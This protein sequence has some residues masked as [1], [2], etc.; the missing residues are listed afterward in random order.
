VDHDERLTEARG[1]LAIGRWEGAQRVLADLIADQDSP[2]AHDGMGTA[3]WW[4]CRVRESLD[5][6][7]RAY[8]G[9]LAQQRH[10]DAAMVALDIG[11]CHV[12]NLDNRVA[13]QGWIA[14]ARRSAEVAG[15]GLLDGWLWLMEAY[16][17]DDQPRQRALLTQT[18][19]LARSVGDP[20]LE[21][22]ALADL[23]LVLVTQGE[24]VDGLTL[25]DE[26]MAGTLGGECQRLDTV[27]W[28][29]CSMLAACSLVGDHRRASQ[30]TAAADR[31]AEKY[32]C[33][34][35]Q[36]RCRSHYGRVLVDIGDWQQAEVELNQA[37]AMSLDCGRE[38]RIEALA[39][40]AE[41]RL[42]AGAVEEAAAM[43][44]EVGDLP[45]AAVISAEV[46]IAQGHPD[47]A[48]A[49]LQNRLTELDG[50][51]AQFPVVAAALV[52]ACIA[53]G[54]VAAA[55]AAAQTLQ[56][57]AP[58]QHPQTTALGHR[59][60][61]L[62]AASVGDAA[63]AEQRLRT[64]VTDFERLDLPFQA[65]RTRFELARAIADANRSLAIV[66]ASR[67]LAGLRRLGAVREASATAQFLRRLGVAARPGPRQA[68]MLSRR[69]REVLDRLRRGLT[70]P[71][72]AAQLFISPRTV[73]H[74]VS[75]ILTKLDLKTR[76]EAAAYAASQLRQ[77]HTGAGRP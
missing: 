18:L 77:D 17:C 53:S 43:L 6:R 33:P 70:N 47:R 73:G 69:E 16:T 59:A 7:E 23:G 64:A 31:F 28:A 22:A 36:A 50:L 63:L 30:W 14:R 37:L 21:L 57:A 11:V 3:L 52:D 9:Y 74:H 35:L 58:Q 4:L 75:S 66:E 42:R 19:R 67:A 56:R 44:I 32:G 1:L 38:P 27:V 20:D 55:A 15:G 12:S 51:E 45:S 65:A 40:L 49:V 48:V 34:F 76:S 72:I 25:L 61:G 24:V 71:E 29:S 5:H 68:G 41:L 10:V 62:V 8:A 54:D 39:G 2:E 60:A 13:A 46:M 26:A